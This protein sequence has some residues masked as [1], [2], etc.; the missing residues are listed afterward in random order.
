VNYE[1]NDISEPGGTDFEDFLWQELFEA[2][3]EDVTLP[4]ECVSLKRP[5]LGEVYSSPW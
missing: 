4:S 1:S 3:R 2:A 5:D